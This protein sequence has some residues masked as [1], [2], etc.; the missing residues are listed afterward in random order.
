MFE[1]AFLDALQVEVIVVQDLVLAAARSIVAS[2]PF[3]HG[4]SS[5]SSR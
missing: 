4:N 2:D 1:D 5:T 3:F